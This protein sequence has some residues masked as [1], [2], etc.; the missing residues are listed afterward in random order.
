MLP[1]VIISLDMDRIIG[2]LHQFFK[3]FPPNTW[4]KRACGEVP[5]RTAKTIL[6]TLAKLKGN[7]VMPEPSIKTTVVVLPDS[8]TDQVPNVSPLLSSDVFHPQIMSHLS[9]V[10]TE[11]SEIEK[12][13]QKFLRNGANG[14]AVND[15]QNQQHMNGNPESG[16]E[17]RTPRGSV[18]GN[19]TSKPACREKNHCAFMAVFAQAECEVYR[20]GL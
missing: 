15:N 8:S 19:V 2:D 13:L 20:C 18:S 4:K 6:H 17:L 9:Q 14:N 1:T 3:A 5:L 7:K 11:D 12:Y 16:V 10:D